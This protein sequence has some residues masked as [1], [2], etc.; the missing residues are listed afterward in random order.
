MILS[1]AAVA[2]QFAF[3]I[4]ILIKVFF[5]SPHAK[6]KI[7]KSSF[8]LGDS[9]VAMGHVALWWQSVT[10]LILM[11]PTLF[12]VTGDNFNYSSVIITFVMVV[13]AINW[14]FNARHYFKGAKSVVPKIKIPT[15]SMPIPKIPK[16]AVPKL[17]LFDRL[18]IFRYSSLRGSVSGL[19]DVDNS[20]NNAAGGGN[21]IGSSG[22]NSSGS[23]NG[24]TR[25]LRN[26][27]RR[28]SRR[29][30][31]GG[32]HGRSNGGSSSSISGSG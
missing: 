24:R 22:G 19:D 6:E 9:S 3:G 18:R 7:K 32:H 1:T 8:Y 30:S 20:H 16:V 26:L 2:Y 27:V 17:K 4:P 11:L 12:P 13:G 15:I 29:G 5:M 23:E 14:E 28:V 21:R 25:S 31:I 10:S